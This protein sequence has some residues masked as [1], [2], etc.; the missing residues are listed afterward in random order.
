MR[1]SFCSGCLSLLSA[2]ADWVFFILRFNAL[3]RTYKYYFPLAGLDLERMQ[4]AAQ[5]FVGE[6]DFRNFCKMDV[7]GG[8]TNFR[9]RIISFNVAPCPASSPD[10]LDPSTMMCEFTIKGLAFLWH[11][12]RCMVAVLFMVGKR[13]EEPEVRL[14]IFSFAFGG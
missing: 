14:K 1:G 7:G 4:A 5:L 11:Q 8:V 12:V 9:R 10:P 3:Y 13:Q 6:H 2:P